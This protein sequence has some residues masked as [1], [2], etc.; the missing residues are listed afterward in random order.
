MA[1]SRK[2]P[3]VDYKT[4]S[5]VFPCRFIRHSHPL[6]KYGKSFWYGE[7]YYHAKMWTEGLWY[8][9]LVEMKRKHTKYFNTV[10][11]CF[12]GELKNTQRTYRATFSSGNNSPHITKSS[13]ISWAD[14]SVVWN[15]G[16]RMK[17]F[18]TPWGHCL[19]SNRE[20][21]GTRPSFTK[22]PSLV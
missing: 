16:K 15:R 1:S 19:I 2:S 10:A 9:L 17:L 12:L 3:V 14:D 11:T 8:W 21:L 5:F 4:T 6:K 20:G 13:H 7:D 18:V 22:S